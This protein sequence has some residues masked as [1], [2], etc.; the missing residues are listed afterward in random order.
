MARKVSIPKTGLGVVAV[1]RRNPGHRLFVAELRGSIGAVHTSDPTSVG[2]AEKLTGVMPRT[3]AALK[4]R[5]IIALDRSEPTG[6]GVSMELYKL[7]PAWEKEDP[8]PELPKLIRST[9]EFMRKH[10]SGI[11]YRVARSRERATFTYGEKAGESIEIGDDAF[12]SLRKRRII[13][14]LGRAQLVDGMAALHSY[15]LA[16]E[17]R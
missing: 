7:A 12:Q 17:W 1:M 3:I 11:V 6:Y 13:R 4:R 15:D 16:P 2:S 10:P 9:V 5:G 8:R 14:D